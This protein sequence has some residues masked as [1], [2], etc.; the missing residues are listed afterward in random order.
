MGIA[1]MTK[2]PVGVVVPAGV[3]GL[4]LLSVREAG[5]ILSREVAWMGGAFLLTAGPWYL[6]LPLTGHGDFLVD[7][8][9]RHNFERAA[10]P[11]THKQPFWYY[12][13]RLVSDLF[14]WSLLLPAALAVPVRNEMERRGRRFAWIW[15]GVV[16]LL[17]SS[18]GSKRGVYLLPLYPGA[19][20]LVG[21]LGDEILGGQA[22]SWMKQWT[23]GALAFLA[24]F[25]GLAALGSVGTFVYSLA[26]GKYR[27][28]ALALL[29]VAVLA[30]AGAVLMTRSWKAQ[31]IAATACALAL[32]LACL[33][34]YTDLALFPLADRYKSPVPFCR[35]VS[36]V[37]GADE[38]IRSFGL[39]RW[40]AAYIFYTRRLMPAVHSKEE[41]ESYLAQHKKV[42]LIVESDEMDRFLAGLKNPARVVLRQDIG[43]KTTAL[44][45]NQTQGA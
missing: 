33:Y 2:G 9:V 16:F 31:R 11:F 25:L 37:V 30:A 24:A 34:L 42:Y 3:M 1:F 36:A 8:F 5:W 27:G 38:E 41:L 43:S 26:T 44:L 39:W 29:P 32:V 20:L 14:P 19:A 18:V 21:K 45:T 10:D 12:G 35:Q 6:G 40:D 7:F 28:D 23:R 15:I 22:P 4:Y 17:F 13:P